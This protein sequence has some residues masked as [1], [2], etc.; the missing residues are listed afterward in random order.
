M[1]AR[2]VAKGDWISVDGKPVKV[3]RHQAGGWWG[4]SG[5]IS[6]YNISYKGG[7]K[8]GMLRRGGDEQVTHLAGKPRKS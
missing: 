1:K 3:T 4:D 2:N 7:S 6:G 5:W 8:S